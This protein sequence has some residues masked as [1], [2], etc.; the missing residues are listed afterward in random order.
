MARDENAKERVESILYS[1]AVGKSGLI[2]GEIYEQEIE[3]LIDHLH[4]MALLQS[5]I[6]MTG[7]EAS[8]WT[9]DALQAV[10]DA[11]VKIKLPKPVAVP[12]FK[13]VGFDHG[14]YQYTCRECKSQSEGAKRST[15]CEDC[16][17]KRLRELYPDADYTEADLDYVETDRSGKSAWALEDGRYVPIPEDWSSDIS[18]A[19]R[20]SAMIIGQNYE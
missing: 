5:G 16:A 10:E 13:H 18:G 6:P 2:A 11:K 8:K 20:F 7:I 12:M 15:C 17:K 14:L 4:R 9:Q 3:P 1:F 19:S